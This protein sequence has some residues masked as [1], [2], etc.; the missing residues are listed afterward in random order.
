MRL[1]SW[2]VNGFRSVLQKGFPE[3]FAGLEKADAEALIAKWVV[4][5]RTALS[6]ILPKEEPAA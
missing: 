2:N 4:P 1:I 3:V 6:V 5:E